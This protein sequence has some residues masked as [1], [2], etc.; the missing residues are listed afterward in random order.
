[1]LLLIQNIFDQL[2]R[3]SSYLWYLPILAGAWQ[4]RH[5]DATFRLYVIGSVCS[6]FLVTLLAQLQLRNVAYYCMPLLGSVIFGMIFRNLLKHI[7]QPKLIAGLSVLIWI[8]VWIYMITY[9]VQEF[10]LRSTIPYDV[11]MMTLSGIY[12]TDRL[13]NSSHINEPLFYLILVLLIDFCVNLFIDVMSN[14]L[15]A[16][17]SDNFMDLLWDKI[18]P[19][20]NLIKIICLIAIIFSV[21]P[22]LPSLD[23]M[24][25]FEH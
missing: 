16:Y 18:I 17:F 9:G 5:L 12:I 1:M 10:Q 24:P 20:Y 23:Q 7:V 4:W 21:R 6:V 2:A 8:V 3:I 15:T 11:I 25:E 19:A 13:R 14:F 22:K